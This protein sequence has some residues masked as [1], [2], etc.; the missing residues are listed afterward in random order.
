MKTFIAILL[1][2]VVLLSLC[3]PALAVGAPEEDSL[4]ALL[5]SLSNREELRDEDVNA[6]LD[7]LGGLLDEAPGAEAAKPAEAAHSI[8]CE[9]YP[10]YMAE[11]KQTSEEG[12]KLYFLDGVMDLPYMEIS[13]WLKH[14]SGFYSSPDN[15]ISFDM[16]AAGPTVT[17]TRHNKNPE[18]EDNDAYVTFDFDKNFIEFSDYNLFTLRV[19]STTP[20]D[21]VT[22]PIFNNR[23]EPMLL[24]KVDTGSFYRYG[25]ALKFDLA[26]YHIDLIR[27]DGLYLVPLAT[28]S[29]IFMSNTLKGNFFFNGKTLIVANDTRDCRELYYD[30]PTGER[31]PELAEYGY[32][33]LC[34]MLDHF[35]GL[36]E[37]HDIDSF[38]RLFENVGFA[39]LLKGS[40]VAQADAAIYRMITDFLDDG[41]TTWY[42]YSY[43]TGEIDYT[44]SGM[45]RNRILEHI[46]RQKDAR[47]AFYPDGVPGYEEVGNTAYITFDG[48][49]CEYSDDPDNYY[50][51]EDKETLPAEDVI[52]LIIRAHAM[53]TRENSPIE[54]VVLDL[55]C[56]TGGMDDVAAYVTAWFLGECSISN[57]DNMTGAMSTT[58]YRADTNLDRVFDEKDNLGGRRLFCLE[59]PCS[60]S[61]GNFVPCAFKES[62]RVT[63]LGRTSGG[64]SCNV[65][66][67]NSAWGTS[68]RISSN[69][70]VSFLKNGSFYDVDRGAEPDFVIPTPEQYYNRAALTDYINTLLW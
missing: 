64:G 50:T 21:T 13:D 24:K 65:L 15:A 59:S 11:T 67:V 37:I 12:A 31:S 42:A 23:G 46:N 61:N 27:Q 55:S 29:D 45:S 25:D 20:L 22:M 34:M 14:L 47:S 60:F 40:E 66:N 4:S 5:D 36:K 70:R 54:N 19:Q 32:N 62:G 44:A 1:S 63:L 43:L 52:G 69:T 41:H 6:F 16:N 18:A 49:H 3:A 35:Y 57:V 17:F 39:S 53:I 58:V 38:D 2:L 48:F 30:V 10:L 28:L 33:E 26:A 56:N 7:A 8:T 51:I 9:S 68:F